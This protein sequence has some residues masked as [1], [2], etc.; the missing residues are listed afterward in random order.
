MKKALMLS[1]RFD[2]I[3]F[4]SWSF[5]FFTYCCKGVFD[6]QP[7]LIIKRSYKCMIVQNFILYIIYKYILHFFTLNGIIEKVY[8]ILQTK[9]YVNGGFLWLKLVI[10]HMY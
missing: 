3:N 5:Y 10:M 7:N 8:F 1:S 6:I 4:V 9:K 2:L